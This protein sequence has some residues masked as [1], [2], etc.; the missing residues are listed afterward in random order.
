MPR[1]LYVLHNHPSVQPGGTEA[2]T[3][4]LYQALQ[5]SGDF[6]PMLVARVGPNPA[7][8]PIEHAES[9]FSPVPGDPNQFLML[10]AEEDFDKLY[11]TARDK[12][13]YTE[14]LRRFL[15]SYK[16]DVVH[17]QHT[18]FVGA[19]LITEVRRTLPEAAI[20][21]TLHEYL[22][23][24][25]HY[26]QMVRS[27]RNELCS[28]ESPRRCSECFPA[29]TPQ[30][31][32]MRKRFIQSHF[33][34]VDMFIAPSHFLM[35]RYIDWGI[36]PEKIRYEDHGHTPVAAPGPGPDRVRDRFA[37]FG[38]LTPFKGADV[39]LRAMTLLGDDVSATLSIHG[40]NLERQPQ[41]QADEFRQLLELTKRRVSFSGPYAH[42]DLARLMERIDWVV[43]PS[44]WWENSPLVI[45]E[46][47]MHG[48]P[49]ICSGIGGM[50]EKVTNGVNGLHFNVGDPRSLADTM[51][52]A[53]TTPGLWEHLRAGIPE[54]N[55][56]EAHV[57]RITGL[58]RE[59]ME[60]RASAAAGDSPSEVTAAASR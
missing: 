58:Y 34:K 55:T 23:I 2:Y 37:F 9:P 4:E 10:L 48:R 29:L 21:Y 33:A 11:M 45:H 35:Q 7:T 13:L 42:D 22:P 14:H 52:R 51:R 27:M 53:M 16:P 47:F 43:V 17:F 18:L 12:S 60:A 3:M 57:A 36:P 31:F 15:R 30:D 59:L 54:V 26:G 50:A 24:C 56:M 38:V 28:E 46:A 39:L 25:N 1:V 20:V 32:F 19:E 8:E 41:A 6:D 44:V 49:V 5:E 40:S